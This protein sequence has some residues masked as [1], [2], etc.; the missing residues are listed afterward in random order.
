MVSPPPNSRVCE[1]H[2]LAAALQDPGFA[3]DIIAQKLSPSD[4][5][6]ERHGKIYGFILSAA[7]AGP[8]NPESVCAQISE[9]EPN[10]IWYHGYI[11]GLAQEP[12]LPFTAAEYRNSILEPAEI[13]IDGRWTV[14]QAGVHMH[15]D[16][17]PPQNILPIPMYIEQIGRVNYEDAIATIRWRTLAGTWQRSTLSLQHLADI[18]AFTKWLFAQAITYHT[19]PKLVAMFIKDFAT[20]KQTDQDPDVIAARFGWSGHD[21]FFI[22]EREIRSDGI[23]RI[24]VDSTRVPNRMSK[25]LAAVGS[26][27]E[28]SKAT[29]V[30]AKREY[31]PH[32]FT[33]LACLAAPLLKIMNVQGAILSLAGQSGGGKT[34][35]TSFGLS[36]YGEPRTLMLSPEGTRVAIDATL[37]LLNNL[38]VAIDDVSGKHS[39]TLSGLVYMVA[40]G[41]AKERG[42]MHGGLKEQEE[43][44][45]LMVITTNN[46][47]LD[48]PTELLAEAERRRILEM[49]VEDPITREDAMTLVDAFTDH[50][51]TAADRYLSAIV[52]NRDK[53]A[54]ATRS[55]I[56]QIVVNYE[57]PDVNRFGVWLIAAACMGGRIAKQ[58]GIIRFDPDYTIKCALETLRGNAI[59]IQTDLELV[60]QEIAAFVNCYQGKFTKMEGRGEWHIAQ[61]LER[62]DICGVYKVHEKV[63]A[64]PAR[65]VRKWLV[66]ENVP[67]SGFRKWKKLRQIH[68]GPQL[69]IKGGASEH[70][71]FI[72]IHDLTEMFQKNLDSDVPF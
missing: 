56:Q 55:M 9:N 37:R 57:I 8:V 11:G 7:S 4:F 71:V 5:Q 67:M 41:R 1:I 66:K 59:E 62:S 69:L 15:V 12:F 28:W 63:I 34:V 32:Q 60:D 36:V 20:N 22:G 47:I 2:A 48:L 61:H 51:G 10:G 31:W 6:A 35:A 16:G 44:Q 54:D 70:C 72:P 40:N 49:S 53:I 43:W 21:K 3:N 27:N 23:G 64:I 65:L 58:Q 19:D 13:S 30:L 17:E 14:G 45:T 52:R 50:Y 26:L 38:P 29:E 18:R 39:R 68:S 24:K 42:N 46:P 25:G 33:L